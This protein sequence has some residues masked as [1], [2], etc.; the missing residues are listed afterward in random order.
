MKKTGVKARERLKPMAAMYPN[1]SSKKKKSPTAMPDR[2]ATGS[3][4]MK[5][6]ESPT[7]NR[8]A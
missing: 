6:D 5:A 4:N 7:F 3:S 2:I 1:G 8:S